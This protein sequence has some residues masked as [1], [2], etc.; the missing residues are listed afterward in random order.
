M[1]NIAIWRA[2]CFYANRFLLHLLLE[3]IRRHS[4]SPIALHL[5]TQMRHGLVSCTPTVGSY[6]MMGVHH[7]TLIFSHILL[8]L[9]RDEFELDLATFIHDDNQKLLSLEATITDTWRVNSRK[10]LMTAIQDLYASKH[11]T[12]AYCMWHPKLKTVLDTFMASPVM[13][14][15]ITRNTFTILSTGG[16]QG[17]SLVE[18]IT[19]RL[20]HSPLLLRFGHRSGPPP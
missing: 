19:H 8:G 18:A 10:P 17:V 16:T 4:T 7:H 14:D 12:V 2:R 13:C 15:W 6:T 9:L 11:K 5:I 1:A 20:S 3:N